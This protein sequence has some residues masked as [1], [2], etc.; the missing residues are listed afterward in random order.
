M[1]F[2]SL[3]P[4]VLTLVAV[5]VLVVTA[6]ATT[7]NLTSPAPV[8]QQYQQTLNSP[9]VFGDPSCKQPSG[10]GLTSIAGGGGLQNWGT[11]VQ[12]G[13]VLSPIYTYAQI[14][15]AIGGAGFVVGID[16]NQADHK[17]PTLTYF[18]ELINGSVVA[19]FG[20]AGATTG[21]SALVLTN[22]GNG[23]A[24]AILSNFVAPTP[25]QTVQFALT[26]LDANDGTEEFFLV[27]T[28]SPPPTVPEPGTL[29]LLGTGLVGLAGLVRRRFLS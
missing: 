20:T 4:F 9:C 27:N 18:A 6:G 29:G 24:D 26:Y 16:V 23:F 3:K 2:I 8:S 5:A 1:R 14:V 17:S 22:N 25:G 13:P 21:G 10:F 28:A 12:G 15:S 11:T 19:T 7:L